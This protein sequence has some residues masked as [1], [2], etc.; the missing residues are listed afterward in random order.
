QEEKRR[1]AIKLW[2]NGM[3]VIEVADTLDVSDKAVRNWIRAYEAGGMKALAAKKRGH[4]KGI[5]RCLTREQESKIKKL[6]I[7]R[8]PDQIKLDYA[9]W[10]RKAVMDLIER[11]CGV[12]LAIRTVGS[13]LKRWGFTPQKP[14]KRAYEQRPAAVKQWLEEDYPEIKNRAKKENA[15][16]YWGDETGIRSDCQHERGYAPRGKTPV[17]HLNA[18]RAS[19]NMIS[20]ITNQGLVRFQIYDGTMN[21]DRLIEFFKRLIKSSKRKV[22]LILDNLRVHHARVVK[23]W[24]RENEDKIEVFYL[25]SYSPELNP[26]EYLNCDLKAGVHSGKPARSKEQ[27]KGKALSHMR[28]LQKMPARVASYFRH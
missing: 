26:D 9:L 27:L 28:K 2:K 16:I 11:E 4:N 12:K 10:T 22:F 24:L 18:K 7:N 21:A 1:T 17:V 19:V 3:R 25:P 6:I 15:E 23:S 14:A 20:A 13:Y 8:Q 5:G